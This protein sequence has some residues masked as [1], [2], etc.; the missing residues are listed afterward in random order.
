MRVIKN[1]KD[2]RIPKV[3]GFGENKDAR[4]VINKTFNI[5]LKSNEKELNKFAFPERNHRSSKDIRRGSEFKD[6]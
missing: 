5:I 2:I 3:S 4:V 6:N 1:I